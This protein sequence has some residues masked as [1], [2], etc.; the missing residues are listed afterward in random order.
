M[1][2]DH[3]LGGQSKKV[4]II[5]VNYKTYVDRFLEKALTDLTKVN[6]PKENFKVY[7]ADNVSTPETVAK[8]KELVDRVPEISTKIVPTQGNGWGHGNNVGVEAAIEDG[9][10]DYFFLWNIDTEY[11]PDS[12]IEV[13]KAFETDPNIGIVQSKLRLY[14]ENEE[15]RKNPL[16]NSRGNLMHYLGFSFTDGYKQKDDVADE[17][18]DIESSS[19][20]GL[21]IRPDVYKQIRGCDTELFMYHDDVELSY[22][23]KLLGYR[24]VMAPRSIIW[25]M[26]EFGRSIMQVYFMERNRY[27]FMFKFYKIKTI[28]LVLPMM[29][30][31]D[32]AMI[33]YSL[34]GK[35]FKGKMKVYWYFLKPSTWKYIRSQRKFIKTIRTKSDKEMTKDFCGKVIFQEIENPVLKYIGN[36]IMAV[37]WWVVKHLM[38]W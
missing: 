3:A 19:G 12:V 4:A 28:L 32:L 8:I 33:P 10:D 1:L 15:E 17:I 31:L 35:W 9:F 24:V 11:D 22:K 5:V 18:V 14:P 20:C 21:A 27:L 16:L 38:F 23:T 25:H 6:Y 29:I 30:I 34:V 7:I 26:Y 13:L 36:P 37:Y 2:T